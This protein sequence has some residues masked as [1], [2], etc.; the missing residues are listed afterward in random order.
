[1]VNTLHLRDVRVAYG[2]NEIIP[3]FTCDALR[4]GEV[5]ALLGPN[6]AGKSTLIKA[7]SGVHRY[8]GTIALEADGVKLSG[9]AIRKRVGY[10][11]QE[12]PSTAALHS[13]ETVMIAARRAR[14]GDQSPE[15]MAA[16]VMETLGIDHL[17]H[18]FLGEL[19]GGQRQMVGM[20][21]ALV[22]NPDVLV[23]DEPTSALD[24]RHQLFLLT[25]VRQWVQERGAIG[26]VAIH[27][28]NLAARFADKVMV[29]KEGTFQAQGSPE[30]V[31][32]GELI[33]D[34]YGVRADVFRH[35]DLPMVAPIEAV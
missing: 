33:E 3:S 18:R 30:D 25:Y 6:A 21:Q 32:T 15:W 2:K 19:S 5:T 14:T 23:L 20:A 31:L 13:F 7:I 10:V 8:E 12:L 35:R 27:D 34:V 28:I 17:A 29:L 24:L 1:M 11:P 4:A 9:S 26:L 16:T 22:T